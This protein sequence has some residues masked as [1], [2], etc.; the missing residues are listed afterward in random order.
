MTP[1]KTVKITGKQPIKNKKKNKAGN[2]KNKAKW[3]AKHIEEAEKL[4]TIGCSNEDIA[5]MLEIH[6][7]T[8][9]RWVDKY[10]ELKDALKRGLSSR[11]TRLRKAMF[12]KAISQ[13]ST[14][15]QI[16]L[17]KNW[18][19]MTDRQ[20]LEHVGSDI[21]PLKLILEHKNPNGTPDEKADGKNGTNDNNR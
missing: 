6:P 8:F 18:L 11:N 15:M 10:P 3:N 14:A 1:K 16:F 17:A 4:A 20:E 9:Y 5:W 12:E 19:G 7:S 2:P 13:G 21:K